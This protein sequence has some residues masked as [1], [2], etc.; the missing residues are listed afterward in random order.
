MTLRHRIETLYEDQVRELLTCPE[1]Q[2]LETGS[3]SR[4]AYDLFIANVV[5]VHLKA[6][7]LV[8]FLYA[9]SPPEAAERSDSAVP[10]WTT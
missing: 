3:A 10:A 7:Q 8:A 1:F 6:T 4:E 9:L 5:R 2:A